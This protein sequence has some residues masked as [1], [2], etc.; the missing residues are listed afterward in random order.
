VLQHKHTCIPPFSTWDIWLRH[1][2]AQGPSISFFLPI[3][4]SFVG[5]DAIHAVIHS[6]LGRGRKIYVCDWAPDFTGRVPGERMWPCAFPVTV[7]VCNCAWLTWSGG[8]R[9]DREVRKY[10]SFDVEG[11]RS[12]HDGCRW[13]SSHIIAHRKLGVVL[14]PQP[15]VGLLKA[16]AEHRCGRVNVCRTMLCLSAPALAFGMRH[17][18][19][20]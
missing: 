13:E 4:A 12:V 20:V 9:D 17:V 10:R 3:L 19:P 16:C 7:D 6:L 8:L 5:F 14:A 2:I 11:F 1:T 18:I 15:R